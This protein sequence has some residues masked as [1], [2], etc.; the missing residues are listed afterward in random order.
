[1]SDQDEFAGLR[2]LAR[3]GENLAHP[4]PAERIRQL[5]TRRRRRR[6]IS[7]VAA[8]IVAVVVTGG[9]IGSQNQLF[10]KPPVATTPTTS[11]TAVPATTSPPPT[12]PTS[13]APAPAGRALTIGNLPAEQDLEWGEVSAWKL[14]SAYQGA[15][16]SSANQCFA[17]NPGTL[18][19]VDLFR[20]DYSL[21]G[22]KSEG[23][24][25]AIVM[26]FATDSEAKSAYDT[27]ASWGETCDKRLTSQGHERVGVGKWYDVAVS[28]GSAKFTDI[29]FNNLAEPEAEETFL[30]AYGLVLTGDR[31]AFVS[32][33][34]Y[35]Q[36]REFAYSESTDVDLAMHPLI[37]SLPRVAARLAGKGSTAAPS[38]TSPRPPSGRAL[39]DRN[40][41]VADDIP[42][43]QNSVVNAVPDGI[44]RSYAEMSICQR[45]GLRG[46]AA[47]DQLGATF[48]QYYQYG[49]DDQPDPADP[50]KDLPD[51]YAL[52]LQF[53]DAEAARAAFYTYTGWV[54]GCQQS[55]KDE[56]FTILNKGELAWNAAPVASGESKFTEIVY[57][58]PDAKDQDNGWFESIGLTLVGHRMMVTVYL[59]YGQDHNVVTNPNG[60]DGQD[61]YELYAI[62]AAAAKALARD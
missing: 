10:L 15:G 29:S 57:R 17:S 43:K 41:L 47:T 26:Q 35:G 59:V 53:N 45:S 7:V 16:Q 1:M 42:P 13:T 21:D 5:G 14:A 38:T 50:M 40:H 28:N 23:G 30:D 34:D 27:I 48:K 4:V 33:L 55:L 2:D 44:G 24:A 62:N 18:S 12:K 46:L 49:P 3:E 19:P 25:T 8:A 54:D 37:G 51:T 39:T 56:G 11:P 36:D 58:E 31:V 20:G 22:I 32:M 52:A 6:H 60:A 9:T 61:P